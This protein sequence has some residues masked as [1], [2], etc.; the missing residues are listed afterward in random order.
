MLLSIALLKVLKDTYDAYWNLIGEPSWGELYEK[1]RYFPCFLTSLGKFPNPFKLWRACAPGSD[2]GFLPFLTSIFVKV[3][4]KLSQIFFEGKFL[5]P[6]K[7]V[8][9]P[10]P[11]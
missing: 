4:S 10:P 1:F 6:L 9:V 5:S 2:F 7:K 8:K 3:G 11:T